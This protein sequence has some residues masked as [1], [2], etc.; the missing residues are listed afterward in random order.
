MT[1]VLPVVKHYLF[2]CRLVGFFQ[3]A[4][5]QLRANT[6]VDP[7][8]SST[9]SSIQYHANVTV[10]ITYSSKEILLTLKSLVLLLLTSRVDVANCNLFIISS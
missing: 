1:F 2:E 10:S 9:L 7:A 6:D 4:A 5:Q 8:L 3:V